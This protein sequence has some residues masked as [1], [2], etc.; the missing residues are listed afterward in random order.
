MGSSICLRTTHLNSDSIYNIC[1]PTGQNSYTYIHSK[2]GEE[3]DA[4]ICACVL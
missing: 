3:V 2:C 1:L 4:C